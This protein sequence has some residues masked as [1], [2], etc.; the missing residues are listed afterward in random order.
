MTATPTTEAA[1]AG[2]TVWVAALLGRQ[3]E[4]TAAGVSREAAM[5]ALADM[6]MEGMRGWAKDE[7]E[8]EYPDMDGLAEV[9]AFEA[10]SPEQ[11]LNAYT[12]QTMG[13]P[14]EASWVVN[15]VRITG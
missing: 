7:A 1:T 12:E 14:E 4:F 13:S 11:V 6:A 2:T 10:M 15:E 3:D 9:A 5:K 8:A